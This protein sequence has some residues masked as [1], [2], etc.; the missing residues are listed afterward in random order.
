MRIDR[1]RGGLLALAVGCA[2]VEALDVESTVSPTMGT[3]VDVSWRTEGVTTGFVRF[4]EAG[5]ELTRETAP[6]AEGREHRVRLV[7]LPPETEIDFQ[8]VS[9]EREI[10]RVRSA[11][12]GVLEGFAP[13]LAVTGPPSDHFIV[14]PAL[15]RRGDLA[16]PVVIDPQGRIV[17]TYTDDREAQVYR[18]QLSRDG[19]GVTY[20]ATVVGGSPVSDSALV[21]VSWDG[22]VLVT[23]EVPFLAHDFVELADG[24]LVTLASECRDADG[25]PVELTERDGCPDAIEGNSLLA[26][27]PDGSV[28][29]LWTTWDCLDPELHPS[30]ATDRVNW[31]HSNALDYHEPTDTYLVSLRNLDTIL[32]VDVGSRS[33]PWGLGGVAGTLDLPGA[34]FRKQHQLDWVGDRLLV[35]DNQGGFPDSRVVEYDFDGTAGARVVREFVSDPPIYTLILGDVHRVSDGST[36]VS[37]GATGL[38]DLFDADGNVVSSIEIPDHILGFSQV[39]A[40]PG[41]PDLGS[42]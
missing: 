29:T 11:T 16:H 19:S 4:G 14:V 34:P 22:E 12:T 27:Q 33:C 36:R 40:D 18:A 42:P 20:S 9:G 25:N 10:S 1:A 38:T 41:R 32:N 26:V 2:P 37:W 30:N 24:T 15:V 35:F 21:R 8:I 23:H 3:V 28:Q 5:G 7:G 39:V 17:W 13:E 31:T 6:T